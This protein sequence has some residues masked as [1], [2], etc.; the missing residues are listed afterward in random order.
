MSAG[1]EQE[2]SILHLLV[3]GRI[4]TIFKIHV[5]LFSLKGFVGLSPPGGEGSLLLLTGSHYAQLTCLGA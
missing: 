1:E 5:F 3:L 2:W 4:F